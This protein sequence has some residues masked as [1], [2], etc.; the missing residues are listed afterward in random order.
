M[1][2]EVTF[3]LLLFWVIAI[4]FAMDTDLKGCHLVV[5]R[6]VMERPEPQPETGPLDLHV[7]FRIQDIRDVP[8]SGGFFGVD[9]TK[10]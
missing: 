8:A 2:M 5:P 9:I 6:E 7:I 10:V 1:N 4:A 3:L